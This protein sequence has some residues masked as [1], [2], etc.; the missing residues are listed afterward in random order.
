MSDLH[1]HIFIPS[2]IQD[3]H[4]ET[5]E[6]LNPDRTRRLGVVDEDDIMARNPDRPSTVPLIS[7][8][9]LDEMKVGTEH[10][11]TLSLYSITSVIQLFQFHSIKFPN[12]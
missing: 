5:G 4:Q 9:D 1:E 11:C 10:F 12:H 2:I 7:M 8:P 6:D 3:V